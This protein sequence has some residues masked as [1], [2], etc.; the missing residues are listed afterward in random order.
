MLIGDK[1]KHG[2]PPLGRSTGV[3]LFEPLVK[4]QRMLLLGGGTSI[5]VPCLE[6]G[7]I[8]SG[9]RLSIACCGMSKHVFHKM[10]DIHE[11]KGIVALNFQAFS[12][13]Q[14]GFLE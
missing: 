3:L 11:I 9:L 6:K 4:F 2:E 14:R 5:E 7:C 12:T 1:V 10:T 13:R 8:Y